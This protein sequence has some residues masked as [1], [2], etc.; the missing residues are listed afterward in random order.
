M[1]MRASSWRI[2]L[3]LS[4]FCNIAMGFS[5]TVGIATLVWGINGWFQSYGA[6][7]CVISLASWFS[8][9]E[10]GRF[11]GIWSTSHSIGEGLNF[12]AT[13]AL[14][15]AL[16]WHWG[17]WGPGIAVDRRGGRVLFR[18]GRSPADDGPADRGRLEERSLRTG[19]G[20]RRRN[21]GD[22]AEG[23]VRHAID[24]P[25]HSGGVDRRGVERPRLRHALRD[26]EL[27]DAL[28]SGGTRL[29]GGRGGFHAGGEH[30][31]PASSARSRSAI[32]R[33]SFSPH[34]GRRSTC[35]SAWS[36]S[37]A[38]CCSSTDP[39]GWCGP[40]FR[41]SCSGLA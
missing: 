4:A 32:Y 9:K 37:P 7:A 30:G 25:A 11:Y 38:C 39:S 28:S 14:V 8:N 5:T 23:S 6:P 41:C 20:R 10:R 31:R 13:A 15:S 24:D 17:F 36:R 40:R 1:P 34:G 21:R 29:F 35:C 22:A 27:G 2:G 33:T 3:L 18:H 12:I 16:G 26:H 19:R